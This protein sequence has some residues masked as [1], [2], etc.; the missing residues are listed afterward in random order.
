MWLGDKRRPTT[1]PQRANDGKAPLSFHLQELTEAAAAVG[2]FLYSG[3]M[4]L[5]VVHPSLVNRTS[6]TSYVYKPI[7]AGWSGCSPRELFRTKY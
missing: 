1:T 7:G 2:L 6:Y 4:V 3:Q 5:T